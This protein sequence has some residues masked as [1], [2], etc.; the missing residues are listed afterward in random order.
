[1]SAASQ[2][3]GENGGGAGFG[4]SLYPENSI[5]QMTDRSLK[6][7][8]LFIII[9][10][11]ALFL[12]ETLRRLRIHP[13]QYLLIGMANCLFFLLLLA[14]SEQASFNLAYAIA[15]GTVIALC[16]LYCVSILPRKRDAWLFTVLLGVLYGYMFTALQSEDYALLIG[17]SG[18]VL[19]L[20]GVMLATRKINWYRLGSR[21]GS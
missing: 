15:T 7:G 4:F 16:T 9:P 12:L 11:A 3:S 1:M 13:V 14:I 6:Y 18:L 8:I 10:F 2:G 21:P 17:S 19:I 5:Y 20:G